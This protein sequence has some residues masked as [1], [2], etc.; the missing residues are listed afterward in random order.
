ML[1]HFNI[2]QC[3]KDHIKLGTPC[4]DYSASVTKT[5]KKLSKEY[6]VAA[7][8]DGVG[9][10][11]FS[12]YG[13]ECVVNSF[14][15]KAKEELDLLLDCPDDEKMLEIIKLAFTAAAD[16]VRA[17]SKEMELPFN[18]FD[19]TLTGVVYDGE[20][21]WFGH[22]G[23][24]GIVA[25]YSDGE[26]ELIT[27]RHKG[28]SSNVVFPISERRSWQFAAAKKKVAAF[29]MMTDGVLDHCV[30]MEIMN[31]RVFFP[32]LQ[33][34]LAEPID[35]PEAVKKNK[36]DWDEFL[37]GEGDYDVNFRE[38][39]GDDITFLM[40]E[41][42]E[43]VSVLPTIK[44]DIDKWDEDTAKKMDLLNEQLYTDTST[45]RRGQGSFSKGNTAHYPEQRGNGARASAVS[46]GNPKVAKGQTAKK[47]NHADNRVEHSV[48]NAV[49]CVCDSEQGDE[50]SDFEKSAQELFSMLPSPGGIIANIGSLAYNAGEKVGQC[51]KDI[52]KGSIQS[53]QGKFVKNEPPKCVRNVNEHCK[54]EDE[55]FSERGGKRDVI[56]LSSENGLD[57]KG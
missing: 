19:S 11:M 34:A 29:F 1:T 42:S 40:V 30:D 52:A 26:Y 24:D 23:D 50:L 45:Y 32:F 54:T 5:A 57:K 20:S 44:F 17:K 43:L 2:T 6:V 55:N 12:Q 38:K 51:L 21:L 3:G 18:Q 10:C 14:I 48:Y 49:T 39:V 8:S 28:I 36:A 16:S 41:N 13:S 47:P 22:I 35:S 37:R 31:N 53:R 25:F 46:S 7:I 33:P 56:I 15:E 27:V 9:N 4:Q